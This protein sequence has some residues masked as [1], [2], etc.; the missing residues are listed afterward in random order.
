MKV[1]S[2]LFSVCLLF[3]LFFL[4]F[5]VWLRQVSAVTRRILVVSLGIFCCA[6]LASLVVE[7]GL[8]CP[9]GIWDPS[10]LTRDQACIPCIAKWI[11]K[12]WYTREV[13]LLFLKDALCC[14]FYS[15]VYGCFPPFNFLPSTLNILSDEKVAVIIFVTL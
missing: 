4:Y 2:N 1:S 10:S 9:A 13:L 7:H 15:T 14:M 12:H 6:G 11:L 3:A 5:S 8:C